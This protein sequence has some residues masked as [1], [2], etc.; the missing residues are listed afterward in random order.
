[1]IKKLN[2]VNAL[3]LLLLIALLALGTA[4]WAE[5]N[6][7]GD[8]YLVLDQDLRALKDD[9]NARKGSV[10]LLFV[11]GPTCAGCLRSMADLNDAFIADMQG[12]D[13][14]NTYVVHVPTLGAREKH[15]K[16]AIPLL[17]GPNIFHYWDEIGY[18]GRHYQNLLDLNFYAW[19]VWFIY[20]PEAEWTGELPPTPDFWQHRIGGLSRANYLD[21]QIFAGEVEKRLAHME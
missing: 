15:V 13:R 18:S 20:G 10:R 19:G 14:L 11:V 2:F 3:L 21:V 12:D 5:P 16:Q 17:N 1:M 8:S 9:F 7:G 6:R 4:T